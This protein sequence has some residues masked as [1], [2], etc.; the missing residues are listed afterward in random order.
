[1]GEHRELPW[2]ADDCDV[3]GAMGVVCKKPIQPQ[4]A[5]DWENNAAFIVLACNNHDRLTRE[6]EVLVKALQG[7]VNMGDASIAE[8]IRKA[9]RPHE[10]ASFDT[11]IRN[12]VVALASL[13]ENVK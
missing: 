4:N 11:A 13:K 1:M 7:L 12:G 6:R 2:F 10:R 8:D 3:M 9:L 5:K